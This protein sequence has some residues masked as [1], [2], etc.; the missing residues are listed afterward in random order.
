MVN[1]SVARV[2]GVGFAAAVVAAVAALPL[3]AQGPG[4]TAGVRPAK[5]RV[6][7]TFVVT[8]RVTGA[9]RP[10][11]V[12]ILEAP[13]GTVEGVRD[14]ASWSVGPAG[15]VAVVETD[16]VLRATAA[17]RV[18]PERAVAV[19]GTDSVWVDVPRVQAEAAAV[20]PEPESA[21]RRADD[22]DVPVQDRA[23]P[24][25][26]SGRTGNRP[27]PL[28]G[29]P[30][31]GSPGV[32]V[33]Y[34]VPPGGAVPPG[35]QP[36][37]GAGYP[38]GTP[39]PPGSAY[40]QGYPYPGGASPWGNPYGPSGWGV[41]SPGRGW[42]TQADGDPAWPEL[43]PRLERYA[44]TTQDD[45]GF[46]SLQA[47]VT[48]ERVF[49]GQQVTLVATASFLPEALARIS[50]P[51]LFPPTAR[52]AWS[53]DVPYAPPV[54]AASGG[55]VGEAHTLMR[56]FFPVNAGTFQVEPVRLRFGLGAGGASHVPPEE[57]ATAPVTVEVIPVPRQRAPPGWS[58]AVGRFRVAAW[59][60]P[61]V[62][63]WGEAAYLTVE[64]SGAG[65]VQALPRPDPG[66]VWGG[67]LRPVGERAM[68]EVR[69]GVVG[70]VKT[71][72]WL[73]V[74]L[75]AAPVRI[76]PVIYSFFDPWVGG[77]GQV[78]SEEVILDARPI[79]DAAHAPGGGSGAT[80]RAGLSW[81]PPWVGGEGPTA[82]S[83]AEG[84]PAPPL[85]AGAQAAGGGPAR[86]ARAAPPPSSATARGEADARDALLALA[87]DRD[88]PSGWLRLAAA[89]GT[90]RPGEGWR[91]WALLAGVRR[92]PRDA[93]L[94]AALAAA[95][96]AAPAGVP[97]LPL[98]S[99]EARRAGIALGGAGGA[100]LLLGLVGGAAA[101]RVSAP[102]GA[103]LLLGAALSAAPWLAPSVREAAVVVEGPVRLRPDP[104]WAADPGREIAPGTPVT[105]RG[106]HGAW[107]QIALRGGE[108]GWVEAFH[109]VPPE[110]GLA[111]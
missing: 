77:F 90:A 87:A 3:G 22:R 102:V 72:T 103:F 105:V 46:V 100:A 64:V 43:I 34:G 62:V 50:A 83:G 1:R 95:G 101:R 30:P 51:E 69:D 94:R 56:A 111:R 38:Q 92:A 6:G 58:G 74:P 45:N 33:P 23:V 66:P 9:S 67:E 107:V 15:A 21:P 63:A 81:T 40:P 20:L 5:V 96:G 57:L 86:G 76:G 11:A 16:F 31:Y 18:S 48:P 8:V 42:M 10:D 65:N 35:G 41:A 37:A 26:G 32:A 28:V 14:R 49:E 89:F 47:G 44:T 110:P 53:V 60:E 91:E 85:R 70:G 106:E 39:Y 13:G 36:S 19:F 80:A 73:V 82:R 71:F 108:S 99:A 2:V 109:V 55:R 29:Y 93:S 4:V 17:G 54:P 12:E 25:P 79:G 68:V 104:A 59:V 78:A 24:P 7:G 97:F 98:T 27:Y 88:D 84:G 52:D 75:E 61:N